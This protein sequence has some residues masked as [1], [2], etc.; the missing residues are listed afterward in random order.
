MAGNQE[1][2]VWY[3]EEDIGTCGPILPSLDSK[4]IP[5]PAIEKFYHHPQSV[6]ER[7]LDLLRSCYTQPIPRVRYPLIPPK[8][9]NRKHKLV[10][11]LKI[12]RELQPNTVL[13]SPLMNTNT[14]RLVKT[15]DVL[16]IYQ[17][18]HFKL[19]ELESER[20]ATV[21]SRQGAWTAM[22]VDA[23]LSHKAG[24]APRTA[25][26]RA[27]SVKTQRNN[28]KY[29]IPQTNITTAELIL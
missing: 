28:K 1:I 25:S 20:P 19:P 14:H 7:E 2:K 5:R 22:T 13:E 23:P 18:D 24:I 3:K 9:C 21:Y 26:S 10:Q 15:A 16:S 11:R 27:E 6:E 12:Q 29:V 4:P 17:F 8:T